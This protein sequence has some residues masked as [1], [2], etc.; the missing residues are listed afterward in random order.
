MT[1]YFDTSIIAAYYCPE[2]LSH[3]AEQVIASATSPAISPLV[4]V[5]F[6]SAISRKIRERTLSENDAKKIWTMFSLHRDQGLYEIIELA[7]SHYSLAEK[8]L[9]TFKTSLRALDALHLALSHETGLKLV[10]G[11]RVL[12]SSA[13]TLGVNAQLI[14]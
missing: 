3:K 10:T 14:R 7:L 6:S 13:E 8:W 1:F 9:T 11:D 4:A 2:P 5:E 12:F